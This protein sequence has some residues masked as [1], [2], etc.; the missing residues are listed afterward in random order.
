MTEPSGV[1]SYNTDRFLYFER[2]QTPD[3]IDDIMYTVDCNT[4]ARHHLINIAR[5]E[6][7]S[8]WLSNESMLPYLEGWSASV[9]LPEITDEIAHF[10]DQVAERLGLSRRADIHRGI[11]NIQRLA[12]DFRPEWNRLQD[13]LY[14]AYQRG[15]EVFDVVEV[16][17]REELQQPWP[18]LVGRLTDHIFQQGWQWA[19]GIPLVFQRTS[20]LSSIC[21][22]RVQPFS[23]VFETRRGE[24]VPEAKQRRM[25]EAL[26]DCQ[27]M[28]AIEQPA[29]WLNLPKGTLR[30]GQ[31][32]NTRQDVKWLYQVLI[33]QVHGPEILP[34][35]LAK[36]YHNARRDHRGK[37]KEWDNCSCQGAIRDGIDRAQRLL[38][39]TPYVFV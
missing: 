11:H 33:G 20:P 32:S 1:H 36:A 31:E 37:N 5:D 3:R 28:Q 12:E 39:A 21:D 22:P 17:V 15:N 27:N 25:A 29:T 24:T 34:Y 14:T 9:D 18:W 4:R 8:L 13:R 30:K 26:E 16:Y 6:F 10:L 7:L 2:P 35:Q 38:N 19:M 23:S